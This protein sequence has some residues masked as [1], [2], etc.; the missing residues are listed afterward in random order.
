M[1]IRGRMP[2]ACAFVVAVCAA[3]PEPGVITG[4]VFDT[5]HRPVRSAR[6]VTIERRVVHGKPRVVPGTPAVVDDSGMYRLTLP[7]GR[8]ILAVT[9]PP[10]GTDFATVFPSYF[11]DTVDSS[12][13]QPVTLQP[14]EIRAFADFLLLDVESHR[15]AGEVTGIPPGWDTQSFAV[16]LYSSSGYTEPLR[17]VAVA[18]GGSFLFDHVPAGSYELRAGLSHPSGRSRW[19]GSLHI[20]VAAPE[21][22]GIQIHLRA[23]AR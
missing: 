17:T 1:P 3:G 18:A 5:Y 20:E 16:S 2:L 19:S 6:V 14:G 21:V 9:P 11:G 8:Y 12:R 22:R 23:G 4:R 13:A 15:L 10:D 7:P